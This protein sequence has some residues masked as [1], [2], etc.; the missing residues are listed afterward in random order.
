MMGFYH[1]IWLGGWSWFGVLIWFIFLV[2]V[3]AALV[4]WIFCCSVDNKNHNSDKPTPLDLLKERYARGE[5]TEK[6]F[7]EKKKDLM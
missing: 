6:E 2:I 7:K 5:I 3:I 1:N 4:K